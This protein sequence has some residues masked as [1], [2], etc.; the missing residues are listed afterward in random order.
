MGKKYHNKDWL[1]KKYNDERLST[2]K[3]AE[4]C[5]VTPSTIQYW[6]D[7][8]DIERRSRSEAT[9]II[10]GT[11]G[12]PHHNPDWL[13]EQ[14]CEQGK[15]TIEIAEQVG[16]THH[17]IQYQLEKHDIDT[18]SPAEA[19]KQSDNM[20]NP[21]GPEHP[22]WKNRATF[23]THSRDGYETWKTNDG[24]VFVHR[25]LAVAEYGFDEVRGKDVHHK[26]KIRWDNRPANID[27]LTPSEHM[28]LHRNN[29][30]V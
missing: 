15:S 6:L 18:R 22:S 26:N 5:D 17:G 19:T 2:I 3:I 4:L 25:L 9:T 10:H 20:G 7:K 23:Y 13:R 21:K 14:Y 1:K 27:I 8:Y 16:L 12:K 11:D 24:Q 30:D 28:A 29:G